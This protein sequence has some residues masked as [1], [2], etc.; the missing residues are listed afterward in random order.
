MYA[1]PSNLAPLFVEGLVLPCL[2]MAQAVPD[3]TAVPCTA[4]Q[5]VLDILFDLRAL[6]A[7]AGTARISEEAHPLSLSS[8]SR[9]GLYSIGKPPAYESHMSPEFVS[10][11]LE[12]IHAASR[13][14]R[15]GLDRSNSA[16]GGTL[17]TRVAE[18]A[19]VASELCDASQS[20][21]AYS[22]CTDP[23][24]MPLPP[25]LW[26]G[27]LARTSH[28]STNH[29]QAADTLDTLCQGIIPTISGM[30]LECFHERIDMPDAH[31]DIQAKH[32]L[33]CG[34]RNIVLD[35]GFGL[36]HK[37]DAYLPHVSLQ[38]SFASTAS[39]QAPGGKD[40]ALADVV[41]LPL[42]QLAYIL[43]GLPT[44]PRI[45]ERLTR[46]SAPLHTAY[47][48]ATALWHAFTST[49][50]TLVRID[51]L[52]IST[53]P[54]DKLDA[55]QSLDKVSRTALSVY[56]AEAHALAQQYG[57]TDEDR[58]VSLV[59]QNGHGLALYHHHTP[60][61]SLVF[62][63]SHAVTVRI[64]PC[65]LSF[66]PDSKPTWSPVPHS[67][68][69][70]ETYDVLATSSLEEGPNRPLALIAQLEPG[71]CV[72]LRIARHVYTALGLPRFPWSS[73]TPRRSSCGYVQ[74][75][76]GTSR[77][78]HTTWYDEESR[79]I[80]ALPFRS[81]AHLYSA[82][83]LLREHARWAALLSSARQDPCEDGT[84]V[85]VQLEEAGLPGTSELRLS[86][87]TT[88]CSKTINAQ[89]AFSSG[90]ELQAQSVDL[91]HR[92]TTVLDAHEAHLITDALQHH[93]R[94]DILVHHLLDWGTCST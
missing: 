61:L 66:E 60:F 10:H 6:R 22:F 32:T 65:A 51:G 12:A 33:T 52:C 27:A 72:P 75:C 13:R 62:A 70:A 74:Q 54:G 48:Q 7:Y 68:V 85:T 53:P 8:A 80:T 67:D 31:A 69:P 3:T 46:S 39:A 16:H 17:S 57:V 88:R 56:H 45:L 84:V 92:T 29:T 44:E 5:A 59:M 49:L 4:I 91:P 40:K 71:M 1:P 11:A 28:P 38:V 55:F 87:L 36:E 94:L 2:L 24:L 19:R 82:L 35:I 73:S 58:V 86:I 21:R 23:K 77:R 15:E 42:Q 37:G 63:P 83:E 93:P 79:H 25:A 26:T 9:L 30:S 78:Y 90:W 81:L 76:L 43:F 50:T 41:C 34:G 89:L 47:T 18:L 64:G 20:V 14:L